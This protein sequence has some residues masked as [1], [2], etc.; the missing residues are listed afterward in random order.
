M[1]F[2]VVTG[3]GGRRFVVSAPC[4]THHPVCHNPLMQCESH[5]VPPCDPLP[6]TGAQVGVEGEGCMFDKHVLLKF[7]PIFSSRDTIM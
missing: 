1:S 3:G 6:Y 4:N 7:H 5:G 2:R